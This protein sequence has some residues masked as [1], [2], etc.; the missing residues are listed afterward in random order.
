[1]PVVLRRRT[2]HCGPSDVD[3]LDDLLVSGAG[4]DGLPERVEVDH[5]QLKGLDAVRLHIGDVGLIVESGQDPAVDHGVKSLHSAPE[6]LRGSG[7]LLHRRNLDTRITQRLGRPPGRH[8]GDAGGGQAL[9]KRNQALLVIDTDQRPG[10][11][12]DTHR[13]I[14]SL[15]TMLTSPSAKALTTRG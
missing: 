4:G 11:G 1:M 10:H 6:H 12:D 5:D 7:Q 15:P 9:G 3:L 2:D 8:D 14:T 13:Q